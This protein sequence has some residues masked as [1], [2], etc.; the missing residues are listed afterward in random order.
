MKT[1]A[2]RAN[3]KRQRADRLR[4]LRVIRYLDFSSTLSDSPVEPIDGYIVSDRDSYDIFASFI[5][6]NVSERPIKR[7]KV[8]LKCYLESSVVPYAVP[9]FDYNHDDLTFGI[10]DD[11]SGVQLK[12]KESNKRT[13]VN[14]GE[15][16]GSCVYIPIPATYF[17]KLEVIL[18]EVE[19]SIGGRE[20][21]DILVGGSNVGGASPVKRFSELDNISRLVYARMNKYESTEESHPSVVV[22]FA[23]RSVWLCCCGN[24]NAITADYCSK[25]GREKDWQL[26]NVSAA[27]LEDTVS[28]LRGTPEETTMHD[29]THYRQNKYLE[30]KEEIEAKVERYNEAM[31]NLAEE[32]RRKKKRGWKV[33]WRIAIAV[34]IGLII[35][36]ILDVIRNGEWYIITLLRD[37]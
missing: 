14:S 33:F 16:F 37:T 22:P 17:K 13:T 1:K 15:S 25:C 5:F 26:K 11:A 36:I 28:K 30:T 19:Y 31:R 2:N 10:I 24:K 18:D 35:Y 21:L 4:S 29:K 20:K 23:T 8:R 3:I 6:K 7:L 34:L 12:F 9:E 27:A 32:E